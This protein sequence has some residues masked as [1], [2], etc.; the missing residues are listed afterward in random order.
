MRSLPLSR[1]RLALAGLATAGLLAIGG[2]AGQA[3]DPFVAGGRSTHPLPAATDD[4]A[5]ARARGQAVAVALGLPG[6]G[7]RVQRLDDAFDHR[8]YDEV[9]S[10]DAAGREVAI[11]RLEL[12]GSVAMAVSLGWHPASG[13]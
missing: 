3:A 6:V 8:T 4:L 11:T 5:R 2:S 1:R 10:T 12:D 9:T 13:R 7:Q